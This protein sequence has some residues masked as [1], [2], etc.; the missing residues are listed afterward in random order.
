MS[1]LTKILIILLTVSSFVLCGIVVNY[2]ANAEN[3]KEKYDSV[4]DD[5]NG[6]NQKNIALTKRVN[7]TIDEKQRL[8]KKL[9][10][11]ITSL[12]KKYEQLDTEFKNLKRE[13]AALEERVTNF[14]SLVEGFEK[15]NDQQGLLLKNTLDELKKVQDEVIKLQANLDETS[16]TLLDKMAIIDTMEREKK[17]LLEEKSELRESLDKLLMS[18]GKTPVEPKPVTPIKE[19]AKPARELTREIGLKGL[20]TDVDLKNSMASISIGKADGVKEGMR[21]HVTRGDEFICDI[22]IIH[23]EEEESVGILELIQQ[24]L[25]VG[26]NAATNF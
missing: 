13:K 15:T 10:G 5:R 8:D 3:Y 9:R 19:P 16:G 20:V 6:L 24:P 25:K 23:I 21:F 7:E 22:L 1:T 11:E 18:G 26:D 14:A 4:E 17:Q 12:K 2:V